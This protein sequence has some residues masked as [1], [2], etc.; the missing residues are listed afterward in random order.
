MKLLRVL[1]SSVTAALG[2]LL[3]SVAVLGSSTQST[4][5]ASDTFSVPVTED[6]VVGSMGWSNGL[7]KLHVAWKPMQTKDGWAI[8]GAATHSSGSV[9]TQNQRILWAGSVSF[10][11]KTI[12]RNLAFF[13]RG[14]TGSAVENA[15][16]KCKMVDVPPGKGTFK[17][18]FRRVKARF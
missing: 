2:A 15:T 6:F 12:L 4:A 8:C 5:A 14:K 3:L 16:A 11:G 9:V 13:G 7:G 1:P 18:D 17:I 10:N